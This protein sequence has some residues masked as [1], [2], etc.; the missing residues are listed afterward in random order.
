MNIFFYVHFDKFKN[1]WKHLG[2]ETKSPVMPMV[3]QKGR[4]LQCL[5]K[6]GIA[7]R[8]LFITFIGKNYFCKWCWQTFLSWGTNKKKSPL[9][10]FVPPLKYDI[11]NNEWIRM[12]FHTYAKHKTLKVIVLS[13]FTTSEGTLP[14]HPFS[15][16]L[17]FSVKI[18]F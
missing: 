17:K 14:P 11:F 3:S 10:P 7:V 4:N 1:K 12:T 5:R 13:N 9:F 8:I 18:G 2:I 15:E 6:V 16:C